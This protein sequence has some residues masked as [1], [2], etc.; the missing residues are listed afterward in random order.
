MR[1]QGPGPAIRDGLQAS[2]RRRA[3]SKVAVG[4]FCEP[5]AKRV[6]GPGPFFEH[7]LAPSPD[8]L[9]R[10]PRGASARQEALSMGSEPLRFTD[11][12]DLLSAVDEALKKMG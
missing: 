1:H 4:G 10:F 9:R 6:A 2:I 3:G 7:T 12:E 5:L 11:N 8:P